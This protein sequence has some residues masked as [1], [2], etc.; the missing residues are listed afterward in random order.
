VLAADIRRSQAAFLLFQYSDD[1]LIRECFMV[2]ISS[3]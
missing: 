2:S 3:E 1:L